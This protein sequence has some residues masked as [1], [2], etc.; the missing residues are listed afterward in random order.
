MKK[1][2]IISFFIL[3]L[4]LHSLSIEHID[5]DDIPL[6]TLS[7]E[8]LYHLGVAL[9]QEGNIGTAV[10]YFKKAHQKMPCNSTILHAL[11]STY[12]KLNELEL[13]TQCYRTALH[14]N[15]Q[16]TDSSF[17]LALTL[18]AQENNQEGWQLFNAWRS[19]D[20]LK[21]CPKNL[22]EVALKKVLILAEWGLGDMIHFSRYAAQLKR[23]GAHVTAQVPN[24]LMH[25]FKSIDCIDA[26]ISVPNQVP[27]DYYIPLLYLPT[28]CR[29]TNQT[30]PAPLSLIGIPQLASCYQNVIESKRSFNVGICWDIG[31][32][33]TNIPAW[34]RSAPL[35]HWA[36]LALISGVSY[37]SL[38]KNGI[39]DIK[40]IASSM[41]I[42]DFG[43]S[44]DTS[45]GAFIDSAGVIKKMDL[46]ISV[47]TAIAHLAGSLGVKTWVLLPYSPDY[48]WGLTSDKTPWYPSMR[49]LRQKRAGD[50]TSVFEEVMH[51]LK[52][53][54]KND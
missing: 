34:Q 20:V 11:G 28:L 14:Y 26:V 53:E 27:A 7:L 48:R 49:L 38:Q 17:G 10:S 44:F 8:Q 50:W 4:S 29:T 47:D 33:D 23:A 6:D 31:H 2:V 40:S 18:L 46:V 30:I 45:S 32:H 35:Q 51:A 52:S 12:R 19:E 9:T 16:A 43:P 24:C 39:Q 41:H 25:L 1:T 54:V 22:R 37:Y 36:P 15:P 42:T 5:I 21:K 3:S 13:A